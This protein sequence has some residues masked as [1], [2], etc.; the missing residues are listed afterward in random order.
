MNLATLG[1]AH[2]FAS[3]PICCLLL[4]DD[5][6]AA[7]VNAFAHRLLRTVIAEVVLGKLSELNH[8][9]T[10][11]VQTPCFQVELVQLVEVHV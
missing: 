2:T 4:H 10:A 3:L 1:T 8:G 7:C 6:E 11:A 9:S 5:G